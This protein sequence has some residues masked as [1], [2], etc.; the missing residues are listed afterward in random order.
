M[1]SEQRVNSICNYKQK[2]R[3]SYFRRAYSNG[4]GSGIE[5][6]IKKERMIILGVLQGK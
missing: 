1:Y 3:K 2:T 4:S 6:R 5:N